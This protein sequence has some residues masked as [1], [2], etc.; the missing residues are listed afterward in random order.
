MKRLKRGEWDSTRQVCPSRV[1]TKHV[2]RAVT[3][4]VFRLPKMRA[5]ILHHNHLL[6][7]HKCDSEQM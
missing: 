2:R 5:K 1:C 7:E 4:P 3:K 6:I